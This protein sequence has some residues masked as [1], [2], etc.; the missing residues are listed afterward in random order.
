MTTSENNRATCF[1]GE[2]AYGY[3]QPFRR[4]PE[5]H[6]TCD[7]GVP[8]GQ[9]GRLTEFLAS[10]GIPF[11]PELQVSAE[12][13]NPIHPVRFTGEDIPE[14]GDVINHHLSGR[15]LQPLIPADHEEW[16]LRKRHA[17]LTM[18]ARHFFWAN[19]R[20]EPSY[21]D[22]ICPQGWQNIAEEYAI[23]FNDSPR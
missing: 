14:L 11:N 23:V 19:R 1:R 12:N 18:A 8:P 16:S 6:L 7:I 22:E 15:K 5:S 21:W 3:V 13:R 10:L 20:T 4:N 9:I 17:L 2:N